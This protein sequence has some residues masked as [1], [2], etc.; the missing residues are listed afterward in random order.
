MQLAYAETRGGNT[1]E[2][3]AEIDVCI[4]G[5]GPISSGGGAKGWS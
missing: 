5:A 2:E 3:G 4:Y 1:L